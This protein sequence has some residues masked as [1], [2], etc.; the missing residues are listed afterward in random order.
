MMPWRVEVA[1]A[2]EAFV[3][4]AAVRGLP[5]SEA[6]DVSMA[7][8]MPGER[9]RATRLPVVPVA[10]SQA[11]LAVRSPVIPDDIIRDVRPTAP[12]RSERQPPVQPTTTAT[13]TTMAAITTAT[14]SGRVRIK[15]SINID[16]RFGV[17]ILP[18]RTPPRSIP[19]GEDALM[20]CRG[21]ERSWET[22]DVN[23][24]RLRLCV[25]RRVFHYRSRRPFIRTHDPFS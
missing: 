20:C 4:V 2:A 7:E 25:I 5:T 11:A 6:A 24:T 1:E 18:K 9:V 8:G 14:A 17:A 21:D 23:G 15:I 16:G 3:A 10:Q 22:V 19:I 12:P 13:T